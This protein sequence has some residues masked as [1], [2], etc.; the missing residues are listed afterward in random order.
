MEGEAGLELV[1]KDSVKITN[2][3]GAT[4]FPE[5]LILFLRNAGEMRVV[6]DTVAR[7]CELSVIW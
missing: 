4:R 6:E 3:F 2:D 5:D 1:K 7:Q